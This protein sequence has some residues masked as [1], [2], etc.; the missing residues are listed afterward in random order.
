LIG[1]EVEI[2]KTCPSCL[3]EKSSG[4]G[5]KKASFF[6][7]TRLPCFRDKLWDLGIR[8]AARSN[9][10][11]SLSHINLLLNNA[12]IAFNKKLILSYN[13]NCHY[14]ES[15]LLIIYLT[16]CSIINYYMMVKHVE[17]FLVFFTPLSRQVDQPIELE[18]YFILYKQVG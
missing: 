13:I 8:P 2:A 4:P 3:K 15:Y 12:T 9:H 11:L 7:A 14:I 1:G 18:A 5:S 17:F 6:V 10:Q 16:D